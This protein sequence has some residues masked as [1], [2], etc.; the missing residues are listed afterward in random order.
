MHNNFKNI[1][2]FLLAGVTLLGTAVSAPA[3]AMK[4]GS[5]DPKERD[6]CVSTACIEDV[7][8]IAAWKIKTVIPVT[9]TDGEQPV[10]LKN[11]DSEIVFEGPSIRLSANYIALS[12]I[13]LF[14]NT[15]EKFSFE[16]PEDVV[17][18]PIYT[19]AHLWVLAH[20]YGYFNV[21][22]TIM[23]VCRNKGYDFGK[24]S[25]EDFRDIFLSKFMSGECISGVEMQY[26]VQSQLRYKF[27]DD[28]NK[29]VAEISRIYR[30]KMDRFY[31]QEDPFVLSPEEKRTRP[32]S[33]LPVMPQDID[34]NDST[35][36]SDL[37][38]EV[39]YISRDSSDNK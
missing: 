39:I 31:L 12:F 2:S 10:Y 11:I 38:T 6:S 30:H 8:K 37:E 21:R 3:S 13:E 7:D 25:F 18:T 29:S 36:S 16:K 14:S 23:S 17:T 4:R 1:I 27:S 28:F 24:L 35:D 19:A 34:E 15:S 32:N 33:P 22:D 26:S 5:R 20:Y 9:D